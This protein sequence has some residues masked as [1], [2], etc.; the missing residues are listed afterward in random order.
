MLQ[1]DG[2]LMHILVRAADLIILHVV[3]LVFCLPVVTIGPA[4]TAAYAVAGKI[5]RDEGGAVTSL[6]L[7][8]FRAYFRKSLQAA[9]L[10]A[11]ASIMFTADCI[12]MRRVIVLPPAVRTAVWGILLFI[13]LCLWIEISCVWMMIPVHEGPVSEVLCRAFV[14]AVANGRATLQM[15][16]ENVAL[17]AVFVVSCAWFPQVAVLYC[18]FGAP[19]FFLVNAA[20]IRKVLERWVKEC[21]KDQLQI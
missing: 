6:F 10:L 21:E 3:W 12:L 17:L 2:K 5:V 19:L 16:A 14:T 18:I 7:K 4:T 13:G 11:A 9:M 20:T 15:F 1:M 8:A